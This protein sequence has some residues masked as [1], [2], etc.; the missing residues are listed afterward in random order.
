M[1]KTTTLKD[2]RVFLLRAVFMLFAL[3]FSFN[4]A[5]GQEEGVLQKPPTAKA[6]VVTPKP[7]LLPAETPLSPDAAAKK[8]ALQKTA[9][10]N[11][12]SVCDV[13][14]INEKMIAQHVAKGKKSPTD[15]PVQSVL[16]TVDG[17]LAPCAF[18]GSLTGGDQLLTAGRLT[19]DGVASVCGTA[20]PC[21]G[22][23][24]S[25]PYFY[26]TYTLK[27]I[28]CSTQCIT[29]TYA[30]N[31]A[32]GNC[33][34]TA[35]NGSFS[36]ANLCTNYIADGGVSSLSGGAPVTFSF[37][38]AAGAT[39]VLVVNEATIS[40]ASDSYTMSVTAPDGVFCSGT[41]P[42][43]QPSTSSVLSQAGGVPVPTNVFSETFNTAIPLPA[44]WASQNLSAPVGLTGWFQGN[45]AVF[46]GNTG[47]GY[48]GANFNNTTG[49]NTI[50][51]WLFTP[52]T[53]LKNGDRFSF[54]TRTASGAFPDRLQV[55]MSTNGASVNAG[56]S[57][58]S[59]GDFS[60][61]LLDINP[62][63]TNTGYPTAWTQYTVT[64]SGLPIAGVSGRIAFRYFVENGGPGGAN[65]DYIGIDDVVYTTFNPAPVTT[66]TGSTA[67]LI[68]T[69]TG[70][71]SAQYDVTIRP[72]IG[73]DFTVFNY[74]S[75]NPIP[76]TPSATT[77]YTLLKVVA[78]DDPCCIGTG[79]SG[80][81]T[82]TVLPATTLPLQINANPST[83]LC[84]GDPTL[85]SVGLAPSVG[86]S[87]TSSGAISVAI[88]DATA[89]G[90]A[91][92]INVSGIPATAVATGLGVRFNITHTWDSDLTIFLKSPNNQVLNLVNQRGGSGA[93]FVNTNV[94]ST[95]TTPFPSSGGA[96]FTGTFRPDGSLTAPAPAGYTPTATT[97][98]PLLATNGT[99]GLGARDVAL[100]DA[101]TITSWTMTINY[102]VPAGA[103][104]PGYTFFWSPAAGLS[105][106]TSNPTAAAPMSTTT[107]TV[108]A[109]AP[110]GCQT[111]ASATINVNQLPA[112]TAQPANTTVCAG[113]PA[114]F[115]VGGSGAG[116]TYRWQIST[117]GGTT[118]T[119][120]TNTAPYSGVTTAILTINP[121]GGIMNGYRYRAVLS[122][123][124]P[125]SA[126]SAGAI[127]TVNE[128]PAIAF[129][130]AS[131]VC[132]GVPGTSGTQITAGSVPP[133]IPGS[134]TFNSGAISVA[135]P[136]NTPNGATHVIP[137]TGIPANATITGAAVT[138]NMT[139]T[140]NGDMVIALKAPNNNILNL[141][142][143]LSSTG[144]TGATT[145]FVNTRISSAGTAPLSSGSG[146]YT[147][148]FRA[149]AV[150]TGAFGPSGPTGFAANVNTWNGLYSVPNGNWTL[151]MWDGGNGDVGTL[152][153]WS[154]VIDYTTPGTVA[155]PLT[156][157]WSPAAGLYTNASATNAYVAGTQ[158]NIVYAAPTNFTFYTITGTNTT[159]GCVNTAQVLVNYLPPAPNV[160]PNPVTMCLGD[161][162]VRLTSSTSS[163]GSATFNSGAISVA[164]PDNT[165]NGATHVIP[166]TGIPANATITGAAVTFNMTHTWN[167][168]M[169]IAL[170]A[171]NNNILNLDYFLSSTGGTGATTGF[172]NTRISSAGTA[173]LSS[174]SGTYTGTF[175]ADAVLTGAFGPSGPT[176]FAANVNTWNGLYSVPNGNWTLAMWDGGNGDVGTLTSWSLQ[177][178]YVQGVPAFPA[179]WSPITG[180]FNDKNASQAYTG[181]ARDTVYAKPTTTTTYSV[182]VNGIGPDATPT[183]ASTTAIAIN[184][185]PGNPYPSNLTVSGL[186]TSGVKVKSVV[187]NG[188]SH[189][190]SD[191]MDIL[192]QS[193]SGTNVTLLSDVG[194]LATITNVTYTFDDA[195]AAMSTAAGNNTGTYKPTN[196]GPADTY[197]APGPGAITDASPALSNFGGNMNGVWKLF[198][199][200]DAGGDQGSIAGGYAIT[201]TYPSQGCTS[202]VRS[203]PVTVNVPVA[204]TAQ[205]VNATVCTDKSTTFS[206]TVTGTAPAHFWQYSTQNGNPGTW[207]TI[208]N[209]G[210]FSGANTATLTITAPPVSM[211]G[212]LF[213]DSV[214]GAAPCGFVAT[215]NARLTVNPLPTIVLSASPYQKLFPGLT[216]TLFST[217]TPAA[218]TY[219]WL[220]NGA[221]VSGAASSSLLVNVDG[222][223]D[224]VVRVQDVNGCVNTSNTVSITDSVSGRVFIYPTPNNGQFQV[225]YYSKVNNTGLPRGIN[226]Y[227]ARGK[228]VSALSYTITAPYARMD[229][230]VRNHGSGT[231]WVEV[232]DA[233]G[234][235]LAMDR[236]V[237]L[238]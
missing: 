68:A 3:G 52:N 30:A 54:Y 190:W 55:R 204:I 79:L 164:I 112:V 73:A 220:R 12:Y 148:T 124:C 165:P 109:T 102:A 224:Y 172:V 97:F 26:D 185:G 108:L 126:T 218:A 166:V 49:A 133:P 194:N 11:Q 157:T 5:F 51:N 128:L 69:I 225:R 13:P 136:D 179:V 189:S 33:F 93:N 196:N 98:T 21:P 226:I 107:Y 100:P 4:V 142:Y 59:V 61:M 58:T 120:L 201:F 173:P 197:P 132:G 131:P 44:G 203:V 6:G 195:G 37:N 110:G 154:L 34:V 39:F 178:T 35:Y 187:L 184:D 227:D 43:C 159:T 24:G 114:T 186:P 153:S 60:T 78:A 211:N 113:Q 95:A 180:L 17:R 215:N 72:S 207:V 71:G 84:A 119:N 91:T 8:A 82:I 147:G 74:T 235:R 135:I 76:V 38:I 116:L 238:H 32:T 171:P 40:E 53:T 167:G 181:D 20:K 36:P 90:V 22:T 106:L 48:I 150:L 146:T 229:V 41:S 67:N 87:V 101:G 156:Y 144:G 193:P 15:N 10:L 237:V 192:L 115:T 213:R 145:G 191:D 70:G 209:G 158:T 222:I 16:G 64:L 216:T 65:S 208:A 212:W 223:G 155:S 28:S 46:S 202:P 85:L 160:V 19:R 231:Y 31:G 2:F 205:P 94:T 45:T 103:L 29:V 62:T 104:P 96:P 56:T 221:T 141:D 127:L 234:N 42:V 88:P 92:T 183:F 230:D 163:T 151:A 7:N 80:T 199:V 23:F 77:T 83:P 129:T 143:F 169:V 122:G 86:T 188:L 140:W 175:R 14:E 89:A 57:N 214:K 152:T 130:P 137:V 138:F 63:Y 161:S 162:A 228:R 134:A 217:V 1:Q 121:T 198:V 27:N 177:L 25:G 174:G 123:I 47:T 149:D 99:W 233:N 236:T 18:N 66:C 117:N 219:T 81:P 139:H 9:V 125:P 210:V 232:V 105:N 176:G 75:G 182:T 118:W 168:D 50:S 206:T 200:D 170:K 111:S